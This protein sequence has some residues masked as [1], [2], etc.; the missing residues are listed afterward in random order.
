MPKKALPSSL[1]SLIKF[2]HSE[3]EDGKEACLFD[4]RKFDGRRKDLS[5]RLA[6]IFGVKK[7]IF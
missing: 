2:S 3:N 1:P 4:P 7:L 5:L 6:E